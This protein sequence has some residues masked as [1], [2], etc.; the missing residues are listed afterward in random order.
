MLS[1]FEPPLLVDQCACLLEEGAV[2]G[3][4]GVLTPCMHQPL[5]HGKPVPS[6]EGVEG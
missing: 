4:G 1:S 3:G 6:G 5:D 2:G